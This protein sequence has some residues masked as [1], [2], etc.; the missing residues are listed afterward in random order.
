MTSPTGA[1]D[2]AWSLAEVPDQSGRRVLVTGV[3]VGGLGHHTALELARRGATVVLAGRTPD[4]LVEARAA[5]RAE[6]PGA[7]LEQ[8][9]V[10]LADLTSVRS[11]AAEVPRLGALDL[12]VHNAGVMAPPHRRT[13]DGLELQLA[14]NHLGPFLLTGLLLPHLVAGTGARVVT[15]S[16]LMHRLARRAPLDE[17]RAA[18]ARYQRWPVY[19]RTKLANLLFTAELERRSR[20]AGLPLT[21]TAAHPGIAATHLAA[22]GRYGTTRGVRASVLHA[23]VGAVSQSPAAG[24]LPTLMAATADLPGDS[25]CGPSG[26]RELAGPPRLVGRSALAQDAEAARALWELS[27]RTV[28]LTWP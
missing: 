16:S 6:V 12:L 18:R 14:T 24:A 5:I 4:K 3:S 22:N 21:A 20:A 26:P 19:A 27:E 1:A 23:A 2:A 25:F 11:A 17:P 13:A 15:V 7:D 9:V 8:V 28:G 10:D